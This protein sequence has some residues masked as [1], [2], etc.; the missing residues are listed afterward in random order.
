MALVGQAAGTD[1]TSSS[2]KE[3][4]QAISFYKK[5]TW[6]WQN[7]LGRERIKE[8]YSRTELRKVGCYT[9]RKRARFWQEISRK[10]RKK[11]DSWFI[12]PDTKD[13]FTAV[14]IA[15]RVFPGTL[16]WLWSCSDAEGAH[17]D[18]VPYHEYGNHYYP[19]YENLDAVGGWMQF[20][21][22]T[23]RGAYR[24]A[25]E[26][27]RSLGF[28]IEEEYWLDA[29]LKPLPQALAAGYL[30]NIDKSYRHHW[31]AS[32]SNGCS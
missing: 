3:A 20:R 16:D 8:K 4:K 2:C 10:F 27:A 21:P 14:R 9:A 24:R 32:I 15:Q 31:S 28:K 7:K 22:S 1:I 25:I 19:G 12:L 6:K 11:H 13:W 30:H 23:F 26:Y 17:G 5:T 29:W 18:W